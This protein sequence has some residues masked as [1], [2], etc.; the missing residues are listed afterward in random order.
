MPE[1]FRKYV[2][3]FYGKVLPEDIKLKRNNIII[4]EMQKDVLFMKLTAD[5]FIKKYVK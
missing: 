3:D 5:E 1:V 4:A 2:F